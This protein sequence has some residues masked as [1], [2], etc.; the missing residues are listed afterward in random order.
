[1]YHNLPQKKG[2]QKKLKQLTEEDRTI[3]LYESTYRIEKLLKELNE[4]MPNRYLVVQRELTKKFEE[5]WRGLPEDIINSL[6]YKTIKGEFVVV[7]AP[8]KWTNN[9]SY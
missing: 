6:P 3:V 4:Y 7:I 9:Y 5:S 1:M 2:R 8:K